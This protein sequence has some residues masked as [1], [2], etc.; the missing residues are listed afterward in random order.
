MGWDRLG[1]PREILESERGE[2]VA[3]VTDMRS[4]N[5]NLSIGL[6]EA[7]LRGVWIQFLGFRIYR[8]GRQNLSC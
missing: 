4:A 2:Q 6:R 7:S 5:W 8:L 3:E 1:F